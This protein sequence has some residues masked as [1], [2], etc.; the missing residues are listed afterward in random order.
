MR[1]SLFKEVARRLGLES[2]EIRTVD[3]LG[4]AIQ[5]MDEIRTPHIE[6]DVRVVVRR[7]GANAFELLDANSDFPDA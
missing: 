7:T 3:V 5:A 2:S 6:V 1:G 4:V